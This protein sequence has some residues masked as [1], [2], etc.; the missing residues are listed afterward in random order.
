MYQEQNGSTRVIAYASRPL[1]P[2]ERN[3]HMH[4]GKLEFL[5][6]NWAVTKQFSKLL[7]E[8]HKLHV[9]KKSGILYHNQQIVLP[10]KF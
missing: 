4:S 10:Q 3:Y 9:D 6:L 1:T 7:N 2:S 5:A 8:R